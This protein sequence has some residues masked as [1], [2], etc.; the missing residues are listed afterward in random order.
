MCSRVSDLRD[1]VFK[2]CARLAWSLWGEL[3]VS[4][5]DRRHQGWCVEL[6]P[7]LA[8]T[9]VLGE[10]ERR[11]RR[12]AVDWCIANPAFVSLSQFRHVVSDPLWQDEPAFADLSATMTHLTG[13]KWPGSDRGRAYELEPSGKSRLR[14]LSAPSLLQLR[15]RAL[16]GVGSR[17]EL[18]RLMLLN[19]SQEWSVAQLGERIAYTQRQAATDLEM[20]AKG[21]LIEKRGGG[22]SRYALRDASGLRVVVGELPKLAPNWTPLFQVLAGVLASL[23]LVADDR[24]RQPAVEMSRRLQRLE[25][26]LTASG[27]PKPPGGLSTTPIDVARQWILDIAGALGEGDPDVLTE[28]AS[29]Q[30]PGDPPTGRGGW[31]RVPDQPLDS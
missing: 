24:L 1:A 17:A 28:Q 26:A 8:F 4:T 15:L 12:E 23:G 19:P 31:P 11:L 25:P 2:S 30:A 20:L 18:V 13:R 6:E 7:L 14:E 27:L 21:G 16:F 22:P 10:R 29:V 5:W 9:A 3:G